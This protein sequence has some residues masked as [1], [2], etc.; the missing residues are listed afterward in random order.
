MLL[1]LH[2]SYWSSFF[3]A[4]LNFPS[5]CD[6]QNYIIIPNKVPELNLNFLCFLL[7]LEKCQ[8]VVVI[9]YSKHG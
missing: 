4:S 9:Q 2:S 5:L 3:D 6:S 1:N 7:F 8:L